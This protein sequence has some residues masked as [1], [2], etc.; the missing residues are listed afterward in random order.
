MISATRYKP[1]VLGGA[2]DMLRS[3]IGVLGQEH[4]KLRVQ[5]KPSTTVSEL[6]VR[7]D[8]PE[9]DI[10]L[11]VL[12]QRARVCGELCSF[13]TEKEKPEWISDQFGHHSGIST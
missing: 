4:R 13:L 8:F 11:P 12:A 2:I 5:T 3:V 10:T 7:L 1:W 9:G 6:D